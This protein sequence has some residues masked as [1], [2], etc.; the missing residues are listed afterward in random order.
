MRATIMLTFVVTGS[1]DAGK[2]PSDGAVMVCGARSVGR[3]GRR[4]AGWAA[5]AVA[6]RP[7]DAM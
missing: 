1:K 4:R 7:G 5:R 2:Q 3:S 6:G